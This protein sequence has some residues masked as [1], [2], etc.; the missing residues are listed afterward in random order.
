MKSETFVKP[1]H[2]RSRQKSERF[3]QGKCR[4]AIGVV[5]SVVWQTTLEPSWATSTVHNTWTRNHQTNGKTKYFFTPWIRQW[6]LVCASVRHNLFSLLESAKILLCRTGIAPSSETVSCDCNRGIQLSLHQI[7][8]QGQQL[9]LQ[10][11]WRIRDSS[12]WKSNFK[13]WVSG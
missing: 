2:V 10:C 1:R 6:L 13:I 7:L 8:L 3:Y 11:I 4:D 9:L 5:L 12:Y